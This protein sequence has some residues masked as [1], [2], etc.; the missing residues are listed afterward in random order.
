MGS[1]RARKFATAAIAA[2]LLA[3]LSAVL[4]ASAAPKHGSAL[5]RQASAPTAR[6][7]N[8]AC[9]FN[10]YNAKNVLHFVARPSSC[11]G[12]GRKLVCWN[13]DYPVYTCRKEHGGFA[14]RHSSAR[15][16]CS[17]RSRGR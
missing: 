12:S 9:A 10:L 8:Y 13:P 16:A 4:V 11:T 1:R 15:S 3:T 2:V 17:G 5:K 14:G 6:T 7:M